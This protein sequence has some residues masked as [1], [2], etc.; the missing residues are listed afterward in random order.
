MQD[1][2]PSEDRKIVRAAIHPAIG[3]A[4]VG[5][6]ES[7]F[8][9]GPEVTALPQRDPGFYRD[10]T[11]ALKRQ[12][13]KFRLY[14]YSAAGEVVKELTTDDA[15]IEW[16]VELANRKAQWYR[17]ITAMDI[18]ETSDLSVVLR[19]ASVTGA[20][21][22]GLAIRP[23][24]RRIGGPS[25]SGDEYVFGNGTFKAVSD[26]YL[27][28]LQTDEQGRLIVLGGRG[29]SKSP[30]GAPP[31][32]PANPDTFN[33]AD[34]WYDDVS[35]GPVTAKMSLGGRAVPVDGAWVVVAPPNYAPDVVGWRTMYD[36][37]VDTFVASGSMPVP[38]VTSFTNDVLPLLSRLSNLQ[39][40]NKGYAAMFGRGCPLDFGD[41]SFIKRL[42]RAPDPKTG[43]DIW[44]ELRMQIFNAFRPSD[45]KVNEPRDWPWIY[46]DNFDGDLFGP[47]PRT[48]LRLPS[49]QQLHLQRWA[50]GEF[51]SDCD[52]ERQ[53]PKKLGEVPLAD[54]PATLDRAALHFCLADAFHPG[55]EMTWPMRH[56]TLYAA[57][58]RVRHR[59][60]ADAEPDYGPA[61]SAAVALGPTGPLHA[62][63]PGDLTRW[64]G[65][66]WQ[67]DTAYCRSGYELGYDPYLP[68]FWPA[69][70]PNQ[71]LADDDYA[72]VMDSGKS[73]EERLAAFNRRASWDRFIDEAPDI[74]KRMERMIATFGAQGVVEAR[75]GFSD[76]PD[77]PKVIYVEMLPE[78]RREVLK[79]AATLAEAPE[80]LSPTD[81]WLQRSGWGTEDHLEQARNMRRRRR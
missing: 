51:T 70:A 33:N 68:T 79:A 76:D 64:M 37:L 39:W 11:G 44:H 18:P 66:P 60:E 59:A 54:Q 10:S 15:E 26:I 24:P 2:A 48:M 12:A 8:F 40:V 31:F 57:P 4:R 56:A 63:G 80:R 42:A 61:L 14:G 47:S 55:C 5:D 25:R 21:R 32:D 35:D 53:E 20:D 62:Q 6:A 9:I 46:G 73:R 72:I 67:G 65:L 52:P 34:D 58:F 69:R 45:T 71:V 13:A 81:L 77:F 74:P 30:A 23:G 22:E 75:P 28:D 1:P 41:H 49:I 7:E 36:L 50:A 19:N 78:I 17:F 29:I 38:S 3:I 27:G 16:T 43:E